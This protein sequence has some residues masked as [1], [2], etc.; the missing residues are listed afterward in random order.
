[1]VANSGKLMYE[2]STE[3]LEVIKFDRIVVT[4][5]KEHI[6]KYV[7]LEKLKESAKKY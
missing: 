4:C 5:L 1:M 6:E 3:S 7:S 2:K